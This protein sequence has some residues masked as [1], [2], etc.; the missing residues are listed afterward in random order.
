VFVIE[1]NYIMFLNTT[2]NTVM[3]RKDT[4]TRKRTLH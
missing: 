3:H 1:I 4:V 2:R